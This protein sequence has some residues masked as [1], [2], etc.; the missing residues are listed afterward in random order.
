M[1]S[2]GDVGKAINPFQVHQQLYGASIMQLGQALFEECK[3]DY[4]Q[5]INAN[6]A[7]YKV[8]TFKDLPAKTDTII[9]E[10]P[11]PE[12]PFG[13]K[14]VGETA[15]FGV[16]PAIA[17]ALYN[18]TGARVKDM[19]LTPERVLRAIKEVQEAKKLGVTS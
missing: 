2:A 19:P 13:A 4:G 6:M 14:G 15:S 11:H 12:G 18:A 3:Y 7:D 16:Q 17:N 8:P 1:V 5:M 9:V 10:V